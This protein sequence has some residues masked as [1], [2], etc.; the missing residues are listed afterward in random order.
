MKEDNSSRK[1][2]IIICVVAVLVLL[3]ALILFLYNR[4]RITATTMRILRLE[5][6]VTLTDNG[7]DKSVKENLRL[8]SGNAL[9]TAVESLVSIGLDDVKI[10]TLDQLS[11]AIFNQNGRKLD[12]EL[13][14]GSLFFEVQKP[15]EDDETMDIK[16][17]TMIVGIRG[18]SG[19]VSVD[20][21]HEQLIVTDGKVHVIGINP[22]TGEVK[23]IDV[24][25]G[26]R[27]T[28]YLYNDR[29]VDSIE[30]KLE[31]IT[32][33]ELPEFLLERLRENRTLLDKVCRETGWDKPWILGLSEDEIPKVVMESNESDDNVDSSDSSDVADAPDGDS[34]QA[35]VSEEKPE[36][37]E[38]NDKGVLTK[39]QLAWAHSHIAFTDSST[40]IRAL[41]DMTLFDPAFYARTNPDVVAKYGTHPDAL[42]YHYLTRGKK[43]GRPPIAPATPTPTVTPTWAPTSRVDEDDD[44]DDDDDDDGS[45]KS[46]HQGSTQ[47]T[48]NTAQYSGGPA[49]FGG[50]DGK[51][52]KANLYY[53]NQHPNGL[54]EVTSADSGDPTTV[55]IPSTVKV[56]TGGPALQGFSPNLSANSPNVTL[57]PSLTGVRTLDLSTS[58]ATTGGWVQGQDMISYMNNNTQLTTIKGPAST[59]TKTNTTTPAEYNAEVKTGIGAYDES[60]RDFTQYVNGM[61]SN[62]VTKTTYPYASNSSNIL[63]VSRN[64]N[65]NTTVINGKN[66][67]DVRVDTN[68]SPKS[69]KGKQTVA[70]AAEL[71]LGTVDENGFTV[72][73]NLP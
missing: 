66:Y 33:R 47:Q 44:D 37:K 38:D 16:T 46:S 6:E 20:G 71:T 70:G 18:T 72:D 31:K 40:G 2:K 59:L 9:S 50:T 29:K 5:G 12:L 28:V 11:R 48:T 7:K 41:N 51:G 68:T 19:W 13:T 15:L 69:V 3:T 45:K 55:T 42:L 58:K 67:T 62:G 52:A 21:E 34:L 63:E 64:G 27:I 60:V 57:D 54:I 30:F 23:E 25:A 43:E 56:N 39:E 8:N 49:V 17:S 10:V 24:S 35:E 14:D 53:D 36:N 1:K 32:E 65:T 73:P 4:S 61:G 26:E 22:V